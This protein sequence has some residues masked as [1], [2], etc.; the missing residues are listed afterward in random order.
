[1]PTCMAMAATGSS[2][3]PTNTQQQ[4]TM[5]AA[6]NDDTTVQNAMI[7]QQIFDASK[8][9]KSINKLSPGQMPKPPNEDNEE[10][11]TRLCHEYQDQQVQKSGK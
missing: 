11:L 6:G 2:E 8:K 9:S 7:A 3:G 10:E 1:M 5:E 4:E